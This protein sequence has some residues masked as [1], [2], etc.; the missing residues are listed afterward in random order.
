M[1][2]A[3]RMGGRAL[4]FVL[5]ATLVGAAVAHV[6]LRYS[7]N[8]SALRWENPESISLVIQ[9]DGSDDI[10]DGSHAPAIRN[11]MEA[12]NGA[13]GSRARLVE[14]FS[15]RDRRDWQ[16]NDV[17]LV[18][19][20][21]ND[22][23]GFF[24]GG[25]GIVAITPVSF[26]TDGRIVDADVLFNGK[27]FS[28]STKGEPGKF[29]V[30]DVA[31]H[32][33]GHLLGLDHSGVCGATMYPYV[34]TRVIL[35]RSLALDDQRGMRHMYPAG[36]F[37]TISG[38]IVRIGTSDGVP[39]AHV[40]ARDAD[41][42]VASAILSGGDGNFTLQGLD[43]GTYRVFVDP[44]DEPVSVF[45]L[46]GGQSV[47]TA[48][49]SKPLGEISVG[50]GEAGS[51]GVH[52]VGE[53]VALQ[54]GRVSDDYPQ[55]LV[56]GQSTSHI[57]RGTG[58]NVGSSLT[59][60]DP[61]V[62]ITGAVWNGSSVAFTATTPSN[63]ALGHIDLEVVNA[64]GDRDYLVGGFEVTPP[65]P[66]VAV[67]AP[68][69]GDPGGGTSLTI[70][71]AAFRPGAR[72][73]VGNRIYRDGEIGGCV[74]VDANTITLTTDTTIAGSHDVVVIDPTGVEGRAA[75]SFDV[76][77]TPVLASVFPAVG[78]ASGGSTITLSGTGFVENMT[79]AIDGVVQSNVILDSPSR[80]RIVTAG[81][82]PGGPYALRVS[83]PLGPFAESVFTYVAEA[84]PRITGITPDSTDRAGGGTVTVTGSGFDENC[85][86]T[87]GANVR[88]G[89]GGTP[90]ESVELLGPGQL[91]VVAPSSGVG[92]TSLLVEDLG[93]GQVATLEAGF[94]FTGEEESDSD[95]GGGCA[96]VPVVGPP[97]WR[98]VIGGAGWILLALLCGLARVWAAP[99][100]ALA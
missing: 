79:V 94:T 95:D 34:D 43:A 69:T 58:L 53:D 89:A 72:V 71:G 21:E 96:A 38:R 32:E 24:S 1:T 81:G 88:T 4:R 9:S 25:S 99:R 63:T 61:G 59:A 64:G 93:T 14:S 18:V 57:I 26:F 7:E 8:G 17:H 5:C 3:G 92:T 98:D 46:G 45:N 77:V 10:G 11:A 65:D 91:R 23:S 78:T 37:A 15:N 54:L 50:T 60:S 6:R 86:V 16:S 67:V 22:S 40:W 97:T 84:D 35:H 100:P 29:D 87:F 41:G 66:V 13:S 82:V 36:S 51:L 12:W 73:V 76:V 33:L 70:S 31:A 75:D 56:R 90:A 20:D 48:F 27:N 30:Q 80:M 42:H 74:V 52:G 68:G 83:S 55:R 85:R 2:W 49:E 47:D 28:F 39:G 44:L 62:A 19:F